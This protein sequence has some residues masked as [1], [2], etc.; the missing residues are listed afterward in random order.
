MVVSGAESVDASVDASSEVSAIVSVV[1]GVLG[2]LRDRLRIEG[3]RIARVGAGVACSKEQRLIFGE[4]VESDGLECTVRCGSGFLGGSWAA[5]N[6]V[7]WAGSCR[8]CGFVGCN[9]A[10]D[11]RCLGVF[12]LVGFDGGKGASQRKM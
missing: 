10:S 1:D 12:E 6:A 9:Q 8:T 7:C 3:V 5:K 4:V 2:K 11:D